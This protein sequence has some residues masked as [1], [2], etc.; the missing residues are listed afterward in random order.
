MRQL[1]ILVLIT[2]ITSCK[3][4]NTTNNVELY[5]LKSST[6]VPGKCQVDPS[7]AVLENAPLLSNKDFLKYNQSDRQFT[8]SSSA[9]QKVMALTDKTTFAITVNRQVIYYG[10]YKP[11]ISSSS[12]DESITMN[13][14]ETSDKKLAMMLG[15]PATLPP[16][17][18]DDQRNNPTLLEALRQ[19]GK[20][21]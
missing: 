2:A 10:Y 21:Q 20:L 11:W 6:S 13:G 12:C 18:I 17:T 14:F 5:L 19:Q 8:V 1:L 16:T 15:Y 4:E 9:Y 7:T 3:K